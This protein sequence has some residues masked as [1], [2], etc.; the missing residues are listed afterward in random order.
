MK[1]LLFIALPVFITLNNIQAQGTSTPLI[2]HST[3]AAAAVNS[4]NIMTYKV[5]QDK[6]VHI[7]SPEPISYVDI[8]SPEVEGDMPQK[9]IF[10]FKPSGT[11]EEGTQFQITVVTEQFIMA[12]KMIVSCN[13][14][15]EATVITINPN[16]AL[17]T[18][19]YNKVG[20]AEFD[21]LSMLA[22]SKKRTIYNI[23]E[24]KN[25]I[26]VHLNNVYIIGDFLLFDIGMINKT[27]L[28]YDIDQIR[29]KL[30]DKKRMAAQ[31]SQEIELIPVYQF[32]P[33]EGHV[34]RGKWRNFYLF[35]K[36]TYPS[37]KVF[38]IEVAEKQISGRGVKLDVDYNPVLRSPYLQ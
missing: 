13:S 7:I 22:L 15:E 26:E 19:S 17:P 8:S 4:S 25:G 36:F 29:F 23:K 30:Q 1:H 2:T 14:P 28:Q 11:C 34:I 31:A 9:N 21:R 37:E 5:G 32:Y 10:R 27:N 33:H 3:T 20:K 18:N 35:R 12:Y 16:E 24:S 6:T 38:N